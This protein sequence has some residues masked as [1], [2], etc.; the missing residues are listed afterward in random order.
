MAEAELELVWPLDRWHYLSVQEEEEEVMTPEPAPAHALAARAFLA[1]AGCTQERVGALLDKPPQHRA[2]GRGRPYDGSPRDLGAGA[3]P[4]LSHGQRDARQ[5]ARGTERR[6]GVAR[7]GGARRTSGGASINGHHCDTSHAPVRRSCARYWQ[8][9]AGGR[10]AFGRHHA[11]RSTNVHVSQPVTDHD[12]SSVCGCCNGGLCV[13][14]RSHGGRRAFFYACSSYYH[15]GR[16]VCDNGQALPMDLIN[17]ELLDAFRT[18]LLN[19]A[20]LERA[21]AKLEARL[22]VPTC[23][24]GVSQLEA[25]ERRLRGEIE[26]LTAALAAGGALSSLLGAIRQREERLDAV[27]LELHAA[28]RRTHALD[29]PMSVVMPEVRRRLDDWRSVLSEESSQAR[30]ML[31]LLLQGR[32][33]FTPR[34]ER[35]AVHFSGVGDLGQIFSGLIDSQALASPRGHSILWQPSLAGWMPRVA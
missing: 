20:V 9:D 3:G 26:R 34:D 11:I 18:D 22:M 35:R 29:V 6:R 19:P 14:T 4:R 13:Q 2:T 31:R 5:H 33:V 15:R 30:R 24:S 7:S 25:E 10:K 16:S 28:N 8:D 17:S 12:A 21:L 1:G 27:R 23:D 32:L